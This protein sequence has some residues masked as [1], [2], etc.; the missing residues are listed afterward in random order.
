MQ[1]E[2]G[3]SGGLAQRQQQQ[4]QGR[5]Q[6]HHVEEV[7]VDKEVGRQRSG[8]LGVGEELVIVL[9][10]LQRHKSLSTRAQRCPGGARAENGAGHRRSHRAQALDRLAPPLPAA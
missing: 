7:V 4:E 9:T 1:L 2:H 5:E 6:L 3:D 8:I 10:F